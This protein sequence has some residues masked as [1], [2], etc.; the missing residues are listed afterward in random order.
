MN[1]PILLPKL[2]P[3]HRI[4]EYEVLS[5]IS[6][7]GQGRVYLSRRWNTGLPP[8]EQMIRRVNRRLTPAQVTAYQ[9]CVIKVPH[10]ESKDN[11]RDEH[12]FLSDPA[13]AHPHVIQL[14]RPPDDAGKPR[15]GRQRGLVFERFVANDGSAWRNHPCLIRA[16]EPGGSVRDLMRRN[17]DEALPPG[18]AVRI[19][20][21]VAEALHHLHTVA[22]IVHHDISPNN[23]V[24]HRPL[25]WALPSEPD[26]VVVDFAAAD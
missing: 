19:T 13:I 25:N 15:A 4:G 9:L 8:A 16:Y 20:R 6:E 23:I 18:V 11:L 22:G 17:A 14:Y 2:P 7:G 12:A 10:P 5:Q 26:C 24:L 21:Q 1:R 3:G